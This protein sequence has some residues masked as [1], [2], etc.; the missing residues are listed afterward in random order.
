M[1]ASLGTVVADSACAAKLRLLAAAV[2]VM[3]LAERALKTE[4]WAAGYK[5]L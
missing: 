2:A 4:A 3:A 1:A 5:A